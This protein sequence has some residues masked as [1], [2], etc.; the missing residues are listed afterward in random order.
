MTQEHIEDE[1]KDTENFRES[2][3]QMIVEIDE[4]S[5]QINWKRPEIQINQ[6]L[7]LILIR[8]LKVLESE[9]ENCRRLTLRNSMLI[10]FSFNPFWDSFASA[11]DDNPGLS[12]V[13]KL[14]YLRNLLEGPAAGAIRGL[15]LTAENYESARAILKKRFEQPQVIINAH[16]VGLEKASAVSAYNHLRR[17]RLLYDR[18]EAH[19]RA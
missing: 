5:T 16:I 6:F 19:V 15:P 7:S 9:R 12:D 18:V 8:L 1:I 17:L 13:D 14:N 11:V 3:H 2:I 10:P 4:L